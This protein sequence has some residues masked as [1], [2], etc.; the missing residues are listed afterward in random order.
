[1]VDCTFCGK[2][3]KQGT[4]KMFVKDNGSV[5]HFCSGKCEKNLLKLGRDP[6][7]FKWTKSFVKGKSN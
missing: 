7:K 4:G 2:K 1:M 3:L 6:R 5:L